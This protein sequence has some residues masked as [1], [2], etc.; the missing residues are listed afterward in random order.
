MG[1][2]E[3]LLESWIKMTSLIKNSRIFKNMSY[4]EAR[5]MLILYRQYCADPKQCVKLKDIVTETNMLKSLVNRTINLLESK[6]LLTRVDS[7]QDKRQVMVRL[8]PENLDVFLDTYEYSVALAERVMDMIGKKD[9]DHIIRI[10]NKILDKK[11]EILSR[12]DLS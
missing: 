4:N 8:V 12:R 2:G 9:T 11:E 3:E 10:C 7:A 5:I 1:R 6:N